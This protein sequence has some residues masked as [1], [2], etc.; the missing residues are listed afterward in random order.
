[1]SMEYCQK[2]KLVCLLKILLTESDENHPIRTKDLC[3]LLIDMGIPC[4]RRTLANDI[5]LLNKNGFEIMF[6]WKGHEKAYY[7]ED[8]T[9][10]ITE[11]KIIIDAIQAASFITSK[12]TNEL[13]SRIA[14]LGGKH[15]AELLKGSMIQFNNRKHTNESIYYNVNCLL[16]ALQSELRASF[17]YYELDENKAKKYHNSKKRYSVQPLALVYNEDNYYLVCLSEDKQATNP[18]RVYRTDRIESVEL[19]REKISDKAKEQK[20]NIPEFTK[21]V[22]KMFGGRKEKVILEFKDDLTK[23]IYDKF[24]E[25]TIIRRISENKCVSTVTVEVSGTFWGWLFQFGNNMKI[26]EPRS[27]ISEYIE[28]CKCVLTAYEATEN[29][30]G[31]DNG[32]L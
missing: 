29:E 17:L 30:G 11:L 25:D 13:I 23:V 14:S 5:A 15:R 8:R 32:R 21:C 19:S 1:M 6:L 9:F 3:G 18:Y 7:I 16:E 2:I 22:F 26:R 4:D 24:G 28:Y 20:V 27:L 10:D 12:K 31:N